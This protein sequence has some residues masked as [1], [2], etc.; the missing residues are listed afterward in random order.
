MSRVL[1]DAEIEAA[2]CESEIAGS[3]HS[4][5]EE[6]DDDSMIVTACSWHTIPEN[7]RVAIFVQALRDRENK[8]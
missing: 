2:I 6:W 3:G 4:G 8:D 7:A 5:S 1:T